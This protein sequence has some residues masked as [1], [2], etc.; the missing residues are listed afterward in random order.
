MQGFR[1]I[2]PIEVRFKDLDVFGHVNNAVIFT[3]IE[4]ARVR[5]LIDLGLRS[6]HAGWNDL[7]FILAHIN[8]DFRQPIFYGQQ[9][10]VG[11]RVVE[12]GRSRVKLEHRVEA[13]GVLVAEGYAF[14]VHYDYGAKCSK[15]ISPEMRAQ[16][17]VFE[18][19]SFSVE[20]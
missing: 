7:A 14:L 13:N 6:S 16:V 11:S 19:A 15:P 9:V 5:Y 2:V 17:E 3:Y 18:G 10:E 8:C 1:H 12:I 20:S 4:T